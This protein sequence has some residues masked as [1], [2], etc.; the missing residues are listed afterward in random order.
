MLPER[1][2]SSADFGRYTVP[3][4]QTVRAGMPV[5][6]DATDTNGSEDYPNARE[7]VADTTIVI[8]IAQGDPGTSYAAGE[9]FD[10]THLFSNVEWALVGTG[11]ATRGSRAA[12]TSDGFTNAAANGN[13]TTRT[14][15][16]GIFLV[17][18]VVGDFVPLAIMPSG[19]NKT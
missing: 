14:H 13:A 6:L 1:R 5:T 4:G 7:A 15:S 16:P 19:L 12:A 11:G 8:G 18:G 17:T 9:Q 2:L 10:V 3:S